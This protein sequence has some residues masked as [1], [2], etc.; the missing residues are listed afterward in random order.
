MDAEQPR[1]PPRPSPYDDANLGRRVGI[2]SV[3]EHRY[4]KGVVSAVDAAGGMLQVTY[5]GPGGAEWLYLE[6]Y[7]AKWLDDGLPAGASDRSG[8]PA[9]PTPAERPRPVVGSRVRVQAVQGGP[10]RVGEVLAVR[11]G[12][13][14]LLFSDGSMCWSG[15]QRNEDWSPAATSSRAPAPRG[16]AAVGWGVGLYSRA[17]H[18]LARGRVVESR[19]QQGLEMLVEFEDAGRGDEW[20]GA[21][22]LR[23]LHFIHKPPKVKE[24]PAARELPPALPMDDSLDGADE[25]EISSATPLTELRRKFYAVFGRRTTSNN[26]YWLLRKLAAES[27][28]GLVVEHRSRTR[29]ATAPRAAPAAAPLPPKDVTVPPKLSFFTPAEA[30][31]GLP[32]VDPQQAEALREQLLRRL[33]RLDTIAAHVALFEDRSLIDEFMRASAAE[34]EHAPTLP[35]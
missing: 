16:A 5:D 20:I 30:E 7:R 4:R 11:D 22:A 10:R 8:L 26:K 17:D 15:L 6:E 29:S 27:G 24:V 19:G 35:H 21:E 28:G 12:Q 2:W 25:I 18:T 14:H 34:E 3:E 9:A 32:V 13:F 33:L 1:T 31:A 23:D